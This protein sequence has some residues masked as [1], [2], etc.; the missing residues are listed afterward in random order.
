MPD[1]QAAMPDSTAVR[2]AWWRAMHV[3]V[4][5]PPH[6]MEDEIGPQPVA[7]RLPAIRGDDRLTI[8]RLRGII[9]SS[10]RTCA[11]LWLAVANEP[12]S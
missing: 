3:Q 10:G 6:V 9:E 7:P 8:Y 4:D 1:T 11:S 5:P 2:I 12:G